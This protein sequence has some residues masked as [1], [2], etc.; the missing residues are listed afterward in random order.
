MAEL[1]LATKAATDE[2]LLFGMAHEDKS[3]E[4]L[5]YGA[6]GSSSVTMVL[7][8]R[9]GALTI[10]LTLTL[11]PRILVGYLSADANLRR[12]CRIWAGVQAA[13]P[14]T[15]AGLSLASIQ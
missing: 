14:K 4:M 7:S 10:S 13:N 8:R 11:I 12:L 6:H 2:Q 9:G 15:K 5:R 1:F 3:Q